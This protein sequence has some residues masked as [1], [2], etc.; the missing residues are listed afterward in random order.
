[1]MKSDVI[2]YLIEQGPDRTEA[3]LARAIHGPSAYPQL[4]N[5]ECRSLA[6]Q[7]KVERRGDGGAADPFRYYPV[8]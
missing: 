2:V 7:G 1:M 3:D 6:K 4:V 5:A 8:I